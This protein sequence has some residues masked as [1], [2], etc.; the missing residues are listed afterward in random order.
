VASS[1]A[2]CDDLRGVWI[3]TNGKLAAIEGLPVPVRFPPGLTLVNGQPFFVHPTIPG[4]ATNVQPSV[5]GQF[6]K[7][8]GYIDDAST[9]DTMAMTGSTAVCHLDPTPVFGPV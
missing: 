2:T 1:A 5:G 6:V 7:V 4:L 8:G 9:Y 3:G